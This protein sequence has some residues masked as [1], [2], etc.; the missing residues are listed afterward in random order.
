LTL[1]VPDEYFRF[2]L[3]ALNQISAFYGG[4]VDSNKNLPNTVL[5]QMD[6]IMYFLSI[7]KETFFLCPRK[8]R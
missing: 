8:S 6:K 4:N 5:Y 7:S 2:T 1:S 3:F